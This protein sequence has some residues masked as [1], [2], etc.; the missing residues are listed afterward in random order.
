VRGV[1]DMGDA[2]TGV[3]AGRPDAIT[4]H[5]GV[6]EQLFPASAE[7]ALIMKC[8]SYSPFDRHYDGVV[9]SVED[10]LRLGATAIAIGAI[11]GDARQPEALAAV[12][13]IVSVAER[14]GLPVV[15][16]FY[17]RG[18]LIDESERH[19]ASRVSYAVRVAAELGVRLVKTDYTG[20]SE[21][22]AEVVDAGRPALVVAAGGIP[23]DDDKS[24]L[25]AAADVC[26]AGAGGIAFGRSVWQHRT[27]A[28]LLAGL[29]AIVHDGASAEN[30]LG[31]VESHLGAAT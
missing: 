18:N 24:V 23:G 22:F 6:A 13:R 30:A 12:G 15:G 5:K 14:Y 19:D 11:V 29:R 10:A 28:A 1:E 2:I 8:T 31:I 16:H 21:S 25:Q 7:P 17:P 27:P 4:L 20:S 3:I 26:Q 9:A